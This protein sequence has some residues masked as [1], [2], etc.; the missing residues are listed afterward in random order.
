MGSEKVLDIQDFSLSFSMNGK[1]A[2]AVKNISLSVNKGEIVGFVGESGC[3]KTVTALSCMGLQN[4][5]AEVSG[6]IEICNRNIRGKS[7]SMIFQEPMAS[8]NPLKKVGMQV[9]E[10][11]ILHG[12]S[13]KE[14]CKKAVY[15]M[16]Q[17]NLFDAKKLFNA[18]PH[19]LSGG[20][21]QRI[22]IASALMN[23]PELLIA[24][25]PTTAL[26][27]TTQAQI[28]NLLKKM[29]SLLNTAILFVSHDL[30]L[31]QKL[32]TRVYIMY[33]GCILE[34]G[35]TDQALQNPVHPYTKALLNALPS[36]NKKN[37]ELKSISGFVPPIDSRPADL[38]YLYE[39]WKSYKDVCYS[40]K[41][42]T[43]INQGNRNNCITAEINSS[44]LENH[45]VYCHKHNRLEKI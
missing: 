9:A 39:R 20:Q 28:I 7:V 42:F 3:G 5:N 45:A 43:N 14:A 4:E 16:D 41:E 32:C 1:K 26:D 10:S 19:Q 38:S 36:F 11:G 13:Q 33:A 34:C 15:L 21:C 29:N 12:M 30:L 40:E 8:L 18:Y 2:Y 25:E 37:E 24:D 6:K 27:A 44:F 17:L 35:K 31:V 23:N 22:M